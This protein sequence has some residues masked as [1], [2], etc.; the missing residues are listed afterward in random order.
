MP[1]EYMMYVTTSLGNVEWGRGS[2]VGNVARQGSQ[3]WMSCAATRVRMMRVTHRDNSRFTRQFTVADQGQNLD[4]VVELCEGAVVFKC[5]TASGKAELGSRK[6]VH[7]LDRGVVTRRRCRRP[8][9]P[10]EI[11]VLGLLRPFCSAP[12]P[13]QM[14]GVYKYFKDVGSS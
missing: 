3:I 1:L 13:F 7:P 11:W 10:G 8:P 2:V 6:Y 14:S 5:S 12:V 4:F 9:A